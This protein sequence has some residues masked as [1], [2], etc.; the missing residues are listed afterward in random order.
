M[1]SIV[2]ALTYRDDNDNFRSDD[3]KLT[4]RRMSQILEYEDAKNKA[5]YKIE[6]EN[7]RDDDDYDDEDESIMPSVNAPKKAWAVYVRENAKQQ[8]KNKA[9]REAEWA[10]YSIPKINEQEAYWITRFVP[11]KKK[12]Q[13]IKFI[14]DWNSV[15]FADVEGLIPTLA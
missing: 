4:A 14:D 13:V 15:G 1:S 7:D 11:N 6:E 8:A 9:S 3:A 10:K 12:L 2:L 5:L